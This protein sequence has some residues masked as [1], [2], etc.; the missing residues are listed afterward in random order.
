LTQHTIWTQWG[1]AIGSHGHVLIGP[2]TRNLEKDDLSDI[3]VYVPKYMSGA[4][5]L[6][7]IARMPNLK[8]LQLPYAGYDDALNV[9]PAGVTLCNAGEVHTQSTAELAVALM[10]ASSRGLDRFARNQLRG[11]W[12]HETLQSLSG[13]SA[14]II[15]FGSIGRKIAE[16]LRPFD[17]TSVGVTR[18]GRNET[19][20]L[21]EL[22]RLL[23]SFDIVVLVTPANADSKHLMNRE[24]IAKLK[25]GALLVNVS[26]G[27]TVHTEAL[28]AELA[29][30]RISAA[31][32]VTDPEPLPAGHPL[33]TF[34]NVLISPHVGGDSSA[35][36][37]RMLRLLD[38]QFARLAAGQNP[39][40][41][42]A[43]SATT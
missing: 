23:P 17:V 9:L 4:A 6:S 29:T 14:L 37:P 30:G 10:L 24:R 13:K 19:R 18:T 12:R 28:V 41:V 43:D 42:V 26:R 40:H 7:A 5:G 11:E 2:E 31:L 21:T 25:D 8:L 32:D 22:E 38:E 1:N 35:F 33:W 15:G 20:P 27:S 3:T 36:E 16:M 39:L 34:E